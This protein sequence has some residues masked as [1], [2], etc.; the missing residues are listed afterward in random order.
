MMR[1]LALTAAAVLSLGLTGCANDGSGPGNKQVV[2]ALGGA[3]LGGFVGSQIGDGTGQLIATAAGT[4]IGALVGSE[5]G[6]GLD[7]V[8]RMRASQAQQRAA[9]APIGE[10]ISWNNPNSGNQG[11]YTATRDGYTQSGRYCREFQET[12]TVDGRTETGTGVACRRSDG[13]WEIMS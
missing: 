1:K 13:S 4:A 3:A 2:G 5:I 12:I 11:A 6:R 9:N 10:T 8:D 7:D